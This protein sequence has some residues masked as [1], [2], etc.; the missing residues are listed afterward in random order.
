MRATFDVVASNEDPDSFIQVDNRT[1]NV[2]ITIGVDSAPVKQRPDLVGPRSTA[3]AMTLIAGGG[4]ADSA[5]PA[6]LAS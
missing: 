5:A 1:L 2:S 3:Q 4:G 6:G